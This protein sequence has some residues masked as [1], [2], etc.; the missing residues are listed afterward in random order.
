[1]RPHQHD[2]AAPDQPP[3]TSPAHSSVLI[4]DDEPLIQRTITRVLEG[5][6]IFTSSSSATDALA[7]IRAGH[8]FD[9]IVSDMAMPGLS[10]VELH[11]A[12]LAFAPDQAR[13]MLFLTGGGFSQRTLEFL[14]TV[15]ERRVWKP[16]SVLDL[17][18]RIRGM[19]TA[20]GPAA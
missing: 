13:R 6:H 17:R 12:L 7:L 2:P 14:E 18:E 9:V 10:G 5:E 15:P 3:R 16:F 19:L 4:I 20:L 1:M 8:R 11:D